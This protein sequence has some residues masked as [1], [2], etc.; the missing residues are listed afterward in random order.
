MPPKKKG[1]KNAKT[2]GNG[3]SSDRGGA[4]SRDNIV[5]KSS[6]DEFYA[7]VERPLGDGRF[8]VHLVDESGTAFID[9]PHVG[10]ITGRMKRRKSQNWVTPGCYVLV[11]RFEFQDPSKKLVGIIHRYTDPAA[12]H[13]LKSKLVPPADARITTG[14]GGGK[15]K[16]AH[17]AGSG[18]RDDDDLFDFGE[19][20]E[21]AAIINNSAANNK[22]EITKIT[23]N[24]TTTAVG[25]AAPA[26]DNFESDSE[27]SDD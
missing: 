11:T 15:A 22:H 26:W 27:G 14:S 3:V 21:I 1:A 5:F 4:E 9:S 6:T 25:G 18:E 16:T 12:R 19:D 20:E 7:L 24:D 10:S 2:K 8:V 13:L 17:G 23:P